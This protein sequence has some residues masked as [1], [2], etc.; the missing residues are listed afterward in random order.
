MGADDS[1][2][3]GFLFVGDQERT[4]GQVASQARLGQ[5]TAPERCSR[6]MHQTGGCL[7]RMT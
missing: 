1:R 2:R 6:Q 5:S 7:L 4:I 3:K